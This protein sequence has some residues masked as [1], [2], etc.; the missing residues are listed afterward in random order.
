MLEEEGGGSDANHFNA[1]GVPTTVLG[2]GMTDCH[3][4]EESLLEE[5]LYNAAELALEIVRQAALKS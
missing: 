4:K 2:V 1:Y 3:T 5:D